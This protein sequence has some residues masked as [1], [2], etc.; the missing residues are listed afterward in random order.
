MIVLHEESAPPT[1]VLRAANAG[2]ATLRAGHLVALTVDPPEQPVAFERLL[3]DLRAGQPACIVPVYCGALAPRQAA[4]RGDPHRIRVL[5]G[6]PLPPGATAAEI[7]QA[8][9]QLGEWLKSTDPAASHGA[10]PVPAAH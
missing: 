6:E 8:L 5:V 4:K 3:E 10:G 2:V 9:G 7:R 1:D